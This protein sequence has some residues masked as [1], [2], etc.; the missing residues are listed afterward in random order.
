LV[1][2]AFSEKSRGWE[3][4]SVLLSGGEKKGFGDR[5]GSPEEIRGVG[6]NP[7]GKKEK[8]GKGEK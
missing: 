7:R 5:I 4:G 3:C 8:R 6:T 1:G 2:V